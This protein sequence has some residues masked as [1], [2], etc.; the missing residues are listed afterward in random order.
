MEQAEELRFLILAIQ[1]EGNRILAAALRPL[2]LTPSQ[3]EV[4]SVLGTRAPMTLSGLGDMLVCE[5]SASPSRLVDRMVGMG[6]V[7]RKESSAD[8]RF[9]TLD[10]TPAGRKLLP[11]VKAAEEELHQELDRL[12]HGQPIAE[13]LTALRAVAAAFPSGRV[14]ER[15]RG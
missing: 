1:R 4:L 14:L 12:T 6:L 11:R 15:R 13:A 7:A 5:T 8:R 10:L 2:G 3:A 9:I